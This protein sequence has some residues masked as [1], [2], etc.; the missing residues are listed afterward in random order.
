MAS[1]A[2]SRTNLGLGGAAVLN[3]GT[4]A[5]TVAAGDDSRILDAQTRSTLTAKGDLY[6]ATAAATIV[7]L[8]VGTDG[9]VLTANAASSPGVRWSPGPVN[10]QAARFGL[11]LLTLDSGACAE[12]FAASAGLAVW[13]L[14]H[15]VADATLTTLGAWQI[16]AGLTSAGDNTMGIYDSA[17]T[18]LGLTGD[19]TTAMESTGYV[20]GTLGSSVAV[21]AGSRY[22]LHYLSHFSG[23]VPQL[24]AGGGTFNH[25]AINNVRPSVYLSAQ[26]TS[27]T[28][29]TPG[30]ATINNAEYFLGAR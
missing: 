26:G 18:R 13:V 12:Q 3:I 29:F 1:A 10:S 7:R 5:G 30:A 20:E 28:S 19:M 23:T 15:C 14:V 21:T 11:Q 24:A 9:Q 25:V 8:A 22:Y 4:G 2:T 16:V 6:A 17:G 27:P